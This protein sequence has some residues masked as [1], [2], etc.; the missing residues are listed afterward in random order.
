MEPQIKEVKCIK[1]RGQGRLTGSISSES[2]D[3]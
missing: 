1:F 2:L 3:C